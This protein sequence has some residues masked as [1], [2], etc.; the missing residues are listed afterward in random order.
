MSQKVDKLLEDKIV[1]QDK[2]KSGRVVFNVPIYLPKGAVE[3]GGFEEFAGMFGWTPESGISAQDKCT[4]VIWDYVRS[5]FK[6]A[7]ILKAEKTAREQAT[8]LAESLLT[9]E[10]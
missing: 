8:Q 10:S 6:S 2:E 3:A 9:Y 7:I 5:V 4:E 1:E